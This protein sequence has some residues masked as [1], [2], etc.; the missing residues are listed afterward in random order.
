MKRVEVLKSWKWVL[1]IPVMF[2]TSVTGCL[3]DPEEFNDSDVP[4]WESFV[5]AARREFEGKSIYVIDGDIAVTKSQ[6]RESYNWMVAQ[7]E[8]ERLGFGTTESDSTVSLTTAPYGNPWSIPVRGPIRPWGR[9]WPVA[10][11]D[12]WPP[13]YARDLSYCVS[14]EFGALKGRVVAEMETATS[15]WERHGNFNFRYVPSQDSACNNANTNVIFS[16]RP[17]GA[18]GSCA[19]FP[20]QDG[21]VSRT[22][23]INM[24]FF[25]HGKVTSQGAF[26]HELGHIL[27]LLHE[28]IRVDPGCSNEAGGWRPVTEFDPNSVMYYWWC[29]GAE[30][31]EDRIITAL[32]AAG[33]RSLYPPPTDFWGGIFRLPWLR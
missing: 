1:S 26:R 9:R 16:V 27:G 20:T 11:D 10:K 17:W 28:Q 7:R 12:I 3:S 21:C 24:G 19:F 8:R 29:G 31:K 2:C 30:S 5:D 33:I 14:D 15:D 13:S 25:P 22:L 6:L 32:D 23:V 4:T 18:A